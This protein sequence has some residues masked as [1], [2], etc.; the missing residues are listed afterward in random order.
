MTGSVDCSSLRDVRPGEWERGATYYITS[1][2]SARAWIFRGLEGHTLV[3]LPD[4]RQVDEFSTNLAGIFGKTPYVLSELPL[5]VQSMQN[6]ALSVFRGEEFRKWLDSGGILAATPGALL[7]PL[8]FGGGELELS[9]K[10]A[11]GRTTLLNWLEER[12]FERVDLV[13]APGQYAPR[14]AIV[15][16]FDPGYA[17]PLRFEFF[18][19]AIESIRSFHPDSQK[20]VATLESVVIHGLDAERQVQVA[21]ILPQECRVVLFEA[22]MIENQAERYRWLWED[23]RDPGRM[24]SLPDWNSV[25][26]RL[27]ELPRVRVTQKVE[28]ADGRFTAERVPVFRGDLRKAMW[29]IRAWKDQGYDIT[30]VTSSPSLFRTGESHDA[31]FVV[32]RGTLTD[33]FLDP[34]A[35][36]VRLS[37]KELTGHSETRGSGTWTK[38][39]EEW[40]DSLSPGQLVVHEDYGVAVFRGT[41]TISTSGESMDAIVLEFAGGERLLV[42]F[43][44]MF[45]VTPMQIHEDEEI[46][47]DSLRGVRWKRNLQKTKERAQREARELLTLYAQRE[48]CRG[49]SFPAPTELYRTFVDAFP[50]IETKDQLRAIEDVLADLERSIPMDRLVVGDVGFGKTE[51]AMR[52]AFRAVEAGMQ[53]AVL[54]PTTILAQ[55]HHASFQTRMAGFPVRIASLSRFVPISRQRTIIEAVGRGE[56]DILIGTQRLLQKDVS[57]RNLGLLV[58]DEEHRFGVMHKE[59]LKHARKDINVLT[60]SATPIPRTLS[61]S[62]RGI[63]DISTI[64]TPPYRRRPVLTVAAPWKSDTMVRAVR[65]ELN[66][67]GQIFY[68]VNRISRIEEKRRYLEG[69]FPEVKLAVAHGQLPERELERIM[70]DFGNGVYDILLCTT[71]IE[72]GLDIPRA[73]TLII[74]DAQELGLAQMYQLR[75]RVGRRE[76]EAYA[77]FFY[78]EEALLRRETAERL[79]AIASFSEVGAGYGLARQDLEIRG[80]GDLLGSSQHGKSDRSGFQFYLKTLESEIARL[81]GEDRTFVRVET[82]IPASIPVSYIP[83]ESVRITLYRRF[84]RGGTP[85]EFTDLLAEVLDRF[86]PIPEELKTLWGITLVRNS[87]ALAGIDTLRTTK[88]ETLLTGKAESLFSVLRKKR[89]WIVLDG[90]AVGPGGAIAVD[91]VAD[92]IMRSCEAFESKDPESHAIGE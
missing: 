61:M 90:K 73:N 44:Q 86:G 36:H 72:S 70:S 31:P 15:D 71:I 69:I 77:Y 79:E 64:S 37:D 76:Q 4:T 7:A 82:D 20:S 6:K 18:D 2:G 65:R 40:K 50:Y 25:L 51:V 56:V 75:G 84:L 30:L 46:A 62:L 45:S 41:E 12:G 29:T 3:L 39:P 5:D 1:D 63:R 89:R 21:S 42:P 11:S 32:S 35:L 27:A 22:G 13:W 88:K 60:L 68:V 14:G 49:E 24:P 26:I 81:R 87:G 9:G 78:P 48:L 67:G 66:R 16:L 34:A 38:Q 33:G 58:I 57:F 74:D 10:M 19:E 83:Q 43:M 28:I 52:A 80:G 55:Q 23:I 92:A 54:V 59:R 17:M 8:L 91:D 85:Q 53:V 47:L